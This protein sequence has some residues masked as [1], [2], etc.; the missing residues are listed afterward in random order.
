MQPSDVLWKTG[1][2][3]FTTILVSFRFQIYQLKKREE[4]GKKQRMIRVELLDYECTELDSMQWFTASMV[5]TIK[6]RNS[7]FKPNPTNMKHQTDQLMGTKVESQAQE[8]SKMSNPNARY[9][10]HLTG[11]LEI[12]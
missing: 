8:S 11:P 12:L 4:E 6:S 5:Y 3:W 7:Q 2:I 1:T 9:P 10:H